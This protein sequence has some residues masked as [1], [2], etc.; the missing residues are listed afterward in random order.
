MSETA[1]ILGEALRQEIAD[2]VRSV[3]REEMAAANGNIAPMEKDR[4]LDPEEAARLLGVEV[5][6]LYRHSKKL[7]F[8]RKLSRK[9]L[10]FSER[11]LMKWREAKRA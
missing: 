9:M 8:A 7:P 10:R 11:G 5:H 1:K 2:I 6:W 4:L 3:L